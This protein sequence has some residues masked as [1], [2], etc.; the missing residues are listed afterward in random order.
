[1]GFVIL[2]FPRNIAICVINMENSANEPGLVFANLKPLRY[3]PLCIENPF[4]LG[5]SILYIAPPTKPCVRLSR[6]FVSRQGSTD[7]DRKI[8]A[9]HSAVFAAGE[10]LEM[11]TSGA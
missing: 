4:L 6:N 3:P 10:N 1:M 7:S 8:S 5:L 11:R 9:A 2:R